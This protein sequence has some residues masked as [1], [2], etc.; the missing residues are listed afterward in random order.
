VRSRQDTWVG[1][2]LMHRDLLNQALRQLPS[3]VLGIRKR[4]KSNKIGSQGTMDRV[5][6]KNR[7]NLPEL[8]NYRNIDTES[9][10]HFSRR[11]KWVI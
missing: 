2:L 7:N 11:D 5:A 4:N 8:L 1:G 6:P 9:R 10:H 3:S